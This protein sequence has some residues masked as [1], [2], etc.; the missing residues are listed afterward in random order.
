[1]SKELK[2]DKAD[3]DRENNEQNI[4]DDSS[5]DDS[6]VDDSNGAENKQQLPI[7]DEISEDDLPNASTVAQVDLF[8]CNKVELN[9]LIKKLATM[10]PEQSAKFM[11]EPIPQGVWFECDISRI[12]TG[13]TRLSRMFRMYFKQKLDTDKENPG[14][15]LASCLK[16]SR[17][18]TSHYI[19]TTDESL[20]DHD[21]D[22]FV[23]KIRSNFMG[24]EFT[25]YGPGCNPKKL[26]KSKSSDGH[27]SESVRGELANVRY[28]T[29]LSFSP[30]YMCQR[31]MKVVL[32]FVK[33]T[34]Q[35]AVRT[36][37]RA[38]AP[39]IDG[40][41]ALTEHHSQCSTT[42]GKDPLVKTYVNKPAKW[43]K[44]MKSFVLDF[45]NRVS[46]ASVKN[47]QLV[48][49]DDHN[50]IYLQ[51]GRCGKHDFHLDF[52]FPL[53]PFQ[54]LSI[55]MSSLDYKICSE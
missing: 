12:I 41:L 50:E 19:V 52:R 53:S 15:L 33:M 37:C 7:R 24:S 17:N 22:F 30:S 47:F 29:R 9:K 49:E 54:A 26:S 6:S 3:A 42:D 13:R 23:G 5:F 20:T 27:L 39:S 32:P 11:M 10:N 35:G 38:L 34:M 51:F 55:A 2:G 40:L 48:Q 44:R 31:Q 21:T 8:H 46:M 18:R 28:P 4:N 14:I 43:N 45:N 1:M 25:A 16:R 36:P